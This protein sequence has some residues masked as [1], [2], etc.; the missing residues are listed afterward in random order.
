VGCILRQAQ[1]GVGLCSFN[2]FLVVQRSPNLQLITVIPGDLRSFRVR[3]QRPSHSRGW[4]RLCLFNDFLVVQRSPDPQLITVIPG[5]LRS[6]RVRGQ[7][8]SHSSGHNALDVSQGEIL[9]S[10]EGRILE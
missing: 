6:F 5:D 2:G 8:P 1:D 4:H 9:R 3:G 10:N 7:R